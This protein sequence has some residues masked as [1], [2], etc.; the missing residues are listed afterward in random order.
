MWGPAQ[1]RTEQLGSGLLNTAGTI[2]GSA[3]AE[4]PGLQ[5]P[6]CRAIVQLSFQSGGRDDMQETHVTQ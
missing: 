2:P 6:L 1:D 5:S 3:P 4:L